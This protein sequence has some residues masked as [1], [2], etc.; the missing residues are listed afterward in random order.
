MKLEDEARPECVKGPGGSRERLEIKCTGEMA[1][2][3][4]AA[5]R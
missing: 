5:R 1:S 2:S 4:M 3:S